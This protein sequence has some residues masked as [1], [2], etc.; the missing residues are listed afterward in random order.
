MST[1]I[2]NLPKP[3]KGAGLTNAGVVI[4]QFLLIILFETIEYSVGK[5][6][7]ITGLAIIV[8]VAGGFYLGR[9][10][11]SFATVVNPPI[12]FFFTSVVLIATVGGAG[13]HVAKFGLDLV[14]TLG[15]AA[16]YLVVATVIGWG[17]HLWIGR[18]EKKAK[19]EPIEERGGVTSALPEFDS[20]SEES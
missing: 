5:V 14:T 3:I 10:G 6:G 13:V 8:A 7:I 11:T 20:F 4:L 16:P 15:G 2:R 18:K 19:I 17:W 1:D 12:V 9:A